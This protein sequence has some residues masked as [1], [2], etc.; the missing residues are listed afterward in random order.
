MSHRR[1]YFVTT[2]YSAVNSPTNWLNK[3]RYDI[4]I[5]V[6]LARAI[7]RIFGSDKNVTGASDFFARFARV[8][9]QSFRVI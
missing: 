4:F 9:A 3:Y 6:L 8:F 1:W 5:A 7:E 2:D